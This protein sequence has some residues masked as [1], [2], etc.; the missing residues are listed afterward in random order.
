M[1]NLF[2]TIEF[3]KTK[4]TINI[5][6]LKSLINQ[7]AL[8]RKYLIMSL[9][10]KIKPP[11]SV[12]LHLTEAC[13]LRCKMCYFWGESGAYTKNKSKPKVLDFDILKNLVEEL[14]KVKAKPF[15][16]LFGGEPLTYPHL[17]ELILAIKETK[18]FIDTPTNGILLGEYAKILVRSGFD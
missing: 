13:N 2:Q 5:K 4:F 10:T 3:K 17:E 16:S 15:Y 9:L 8:K 1:N 18:A 6:T 7:S 11:S 14:T 12:G